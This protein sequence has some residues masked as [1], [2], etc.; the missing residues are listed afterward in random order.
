MMIISGNFYFN[1]CTLSQVKFHVKITQQLRTMF[2]VTR[3]GFHT[4]KEP[5]EGRIGN[6]NEV[7][8]AKGKRSAWRNAC[9]AGNF[10]SF[11]LIRTDQIFS[12][13]GTTNRRLWNDQIYAF[14]VQLRYCF[15]LQL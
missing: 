8:I 15:W 12:A 4:H 5:N 2:V 11:H 3:R 6:C 7:R 13:S 1:L 9:C 14:N 10:P